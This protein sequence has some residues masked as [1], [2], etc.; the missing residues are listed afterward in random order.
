VWSQP[1]NLKLDEDKD[2]KH[3]QTAGHSSRFVG[4]AVAK[5]L[6]LA[7]LKVRI[8]GDGPLSVA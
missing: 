4:E 7:F 5:E 3:D 8:S 2:F 6:V 1:L